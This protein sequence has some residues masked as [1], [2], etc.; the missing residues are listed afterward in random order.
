M[1]DR[2]LAVE[3]LG[4]AA[5]RTPSSCA[6]A[7][8]EREG[9][10]ENSAGGIWD[11][12]VGEAATYRA[13]ASRGSGRGNQR[14][15]EPQRTW[16]CFQRQDVCEQG[17][18][19]W[20]GG[21]SF[22]LFLLTLKPCPPPDGTQPTERERGREGT[23]AGITPLHFCIFRGNN[24]QAS[25]FPVRLG[26][27]FCAHPFLRQRERESSGLQ[28]CFAPGCKKSKA[29]R[30]TRDVG[31]VVSCLELEM[32]ASMCRCICCVN[33]RL[34]YLS[35]MHTASFTVNHLSLSAHLRW[36]V[37]AI[38]LIDRGESD[39]N[40]GDNGGQTPCHIACYR[41]REIIVERGARAET[42]PER[43]WSTKKSMP[44]NN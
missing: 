36:H 21:P 31:C 35:L 44:K 37:Q 32:P 6:S 42:W 27:R 28:R 41:V 3:T 15:P 5:P 40:V 26:G 24:E 10:R 1:P 13:Q 34:Y 39:L 30:R 33:C 23:M 11:V 19:V 2:N 9:E 4:V 22:S 43:C 20:G 17:E 29:P 7:A 12:V 38:S 16:F 25:C 8:G 18:R 14:R